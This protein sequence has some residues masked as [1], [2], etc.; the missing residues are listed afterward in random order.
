MNDK[1]IILDPSILTLS[2]LNLHKLANELR[3]FKEESRY[4]LFMSEH[5][6][7]LIQHNFEEFARILE[8]FSYPKITRNK[9]KFWIEKAILNHHIAI[10][11]SEIEE[12]LLYL[13]T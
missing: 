2:H 10:S 3:R 9:N 4:R 11:L 8:Y 6:Y 1:N 12:P 7:H 5:L 13:T